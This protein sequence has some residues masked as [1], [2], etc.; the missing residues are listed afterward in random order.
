MSTEFSR[1]YEIYE[2][3]VGDLA[4]DT[5]QDGIVREV[6]RLGVKSGRVLDVGAGSGIGARLLGEKGDFHITALDRSLEMLGYAGS[7]YDEVVVGGFCS[8]GDSSLEP[9]DLIVSGFDS[10]NYL[11]EAE[12]EKFFT[13]CSQILKTEGKMIFDYSSPKLLWEEWREKS[14]VQELGKGTLCWSHRLDE[15]TKGS[16]I[17]LSFVDK[18]GKEVWQENHTQ[19]SHDTYTM[20]RLAKEAGLVIA[21]IRNL[22]D[23]GFSPD[24]NTHVYVMELN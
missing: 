9:F 18:S 6:V 5:W 24:R 23:D 19:Y 10:L 13:S 14:S 17:T 21:S 2:E 11:N 12:L 4:R 3:S 15:E 8:I 20:H 16:L 7:I 22:G 1:W